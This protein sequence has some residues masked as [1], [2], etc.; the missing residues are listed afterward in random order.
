MHV[1]TQVG[2]CRLVPR[3]AL[4]YPNGHDVRMSN[5][6][7]KAGTA[8]ASALDQVTPARGYLAALITLLIVVHGLTPKRFLVDG[9]SVGLLGVL[10]IV[11]LVP[12]LKSAT[13]PGGGGVEFRHDLDQLRAQSEQAAD[14]QLR[15]VERSPQGSDTSER[16]A[17]RSAGGASTAA[18]DSTDVVVDEILSE[19]ARS[20]RVGLMLLSAELER[21]VRRLLLSSGW[22]DR[23]STTSLRLGVERLVELGVLTASAASA[24]S[25]FTSVRNEIVH[26][27][28][29]ASDE[30]VLRAIDSGIPLLRAIGA[31]PRERNVVAHQLVTVFSDDQGMVPLPDVRGLILETVSPGGVETSRRIFP[32][33]R[34]QDAYPVGAEVSWEW[35]SRQWGEA[36]YRDPDT[37][38]ILP[39]WLGSLEFAG[40]PLA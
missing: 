17:E 36:W 20:P 8:I 14:D 12:L 10:V 31:I 15:Q 21:F 35:G 28:R 22:G 26:G 2:R 37:S 3:D 16:D 18:M 39:A 5:L 13:L 25:F 32:T 11:V 30:E 4:A 23:R 6:L 40:R 1:A 33:T 24:L 9:V 38:E 7:R 27:L 19:A 29:V 34:E